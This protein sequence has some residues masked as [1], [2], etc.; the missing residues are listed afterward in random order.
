MGWM[1]LF[2]A[3]P[4]WATSVNWVRRKYYS[5]FKLAH[6]LFIGVFVFGVMHVGTPFLS[7]SNDNNQ[8]N[9]GTSPPQRRD[10]VGSKRFPHNKCKTCFVLFL[11]LFG[12]IVFVARQISTCTTCRGFV[13]RCPA[14]CS[15]VDDPRPAVKM[16]W[17]GEAEPADGVLL[18]LPETMSAN[19][20][21][22]PH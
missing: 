6:W 3:L 9:D 16:F 21:F 17:L 13:S 19:N 14:S 7:V 2:C 10:S 11:H 4:M 20:C 22:V 1:A 5:L 15:T 12:G 18:S 8:V